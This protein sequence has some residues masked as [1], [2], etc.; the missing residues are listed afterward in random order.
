[1]DDNAMDPVLFFGKKIFR[2]MLSERRSVTLRV[3]KSLKT[4]EIIMADNKEVFIASIRGRKQII[5]KDEIWFAESIGR[6]VS[7]YL[8]D[9][10][11]EV[12]SRMADLISDLGSGFFQTHRSYIVNL[13]HVACYERN[14]IMLQN[15][16]KVPLSRQKYREFQKAYLTR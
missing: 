13:D 3:A 11:V 8:E 9:R 15:K 4:E 6:K 7:L 16:T 12:Y 14:E 1:M 10:N 2:N 5:D